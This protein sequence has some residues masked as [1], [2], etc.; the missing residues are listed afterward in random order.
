MSNTG[1]ISSTLFLLY[2]CSVNFCLLCAHFVNVAPHCALHFQIS[3]SAT[4]GAPGEVANPGLMNA[5][6][7]DCQ[8]ISGCLLGLKPGLPF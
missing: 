2:P 6:D 8:S 4:N 3:F 7:A 5:I 1:L